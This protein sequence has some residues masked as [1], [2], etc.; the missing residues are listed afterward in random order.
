[1]HV[2]SR[3]LIAA[4]GAAV[5]LVAAIP[6]T[7][8]AI[9]TITTKGKSFNLNVKCKA[10]PA[11]VYGSDSGYYGGNGCSGSVL[12]SASNSALASAAAK[13]GGGKYNAAGG[14][15]ARSRVNLNGASRK[16]LR[17][18]GTLVVNVR[19]RRSGGS[20]TASA[21]RRVRL[22]LLQSRGPRF[23]G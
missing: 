2:R 8:A 5:V 16:A 21:P 19:L 15:T 23:T 4:I 22:K 17:R 6:A 13:A 14:A 9:P 20:G 11:G 10:G 18:R 7:A 1:M 3:S 12:I